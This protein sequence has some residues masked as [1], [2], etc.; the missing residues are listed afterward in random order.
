[1]GS[2]IKY[3][4][5]RPQQSTSAPKNS[6]LKKLLAVFATVPFFGIYT[7]CNNVQ[8]ARVERSN[9]LKMQF[10][11]ELRP[12]WEAMLQAWRG[13]NNSKRDKLIASVEGGHKAQIAYSDKVI[14]EHLNHDDVY[15][16]NDFFSVVA[17]CIDQSQCDKGTTVEHF[18]EHIH[19]YITYNAVFICRE[20]I[21]SHDPD[22]AEDAVKLF[23]LT[24]NIQAT[25]D[26]FIESECIIKM[27][28][29]RKAVD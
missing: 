1:M 26:D 18:K 8:S 4:Q 15:H 9:E 14:K 16:L 27:G 2:K 23:M 21:D 25:H 19:H 12:R 11:K 22:F 17:S 28:L 5:D 3:Q 7:Y 20:V 6:R 29:Y 24:K 13:K 10:D